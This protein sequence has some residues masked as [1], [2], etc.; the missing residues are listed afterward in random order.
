MRR[1]DLATAGVALMP[2]CGLLLGLAAAIPAAGR[3]A[4]GGQAAGSEHRGES[5]GW[6][7]PAGWLRRSRENFQR[8]MHLLAERSAR[9][10]R[11]LS[12][13]EPEPLGPER[14]EPEWPSAA[15]GETEG[16][17]PEPDGDGPDQPWPAG[18]PDNRVERRRTAGM[19]RDRSMT[20]A[21]DWHKRWSH[22]CRRAGRAV[23]GAGWYVVAPGDT[24]QRIAWLHYGNE[25][26]WRRILHVNGGTISDPDLIH[27]CQRLFIPRRHTGWPGCQDSPVDPGPVCDLPLPPPV[28]RGPGG[29]SRCGAG[30]HVGERGWR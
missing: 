1:C 24:L 25:G 30:T 9:L 13:P 17:S 16:G 3:E 22:S 15:P 10:H 2:L 11:P 6:E 21:R 4:E 23:E 29:C 27:A 19:D 20:L 5:V 26:A 8:M 18:P 14:S 12:T 28:H 7:M